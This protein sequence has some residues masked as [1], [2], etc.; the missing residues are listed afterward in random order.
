[1]K[2][3]DQG[4]V[5]VA[6]E[7][8]L[9]RR[10]RIIRDTFPEAY[11]D[12]VLDV[13]TLAALI[14]ASETPEQE[15]YA[16]NW[17]GKSDSLRSQQRPSVASLQPDLERSLG[18]FDA[19]ENVYIEGD[20]LEVLRL[21]QRGY[22]DRIRL[23]YLDPPYNTTNDFVYNDDFT[24]S[25]QTYLEYSGQVNSKGN[26]VSATI[27]T[28]GR[29]HSGWLSFMYPRLALSRN[30]LREDGAIFISIDDNEVHNLR[31]LMDSVFGPENFIGQFIWA[32][33]RKND[34]KFVSESHEYIVVYAR[35]KAQ[36][37]ASVGEWK[38]R[39][40]GLD[41]IYAQ[42]R[43]LK[44]KH[45]KDFSA[46]TEDLKAWY[47]SLAN[48]NPAKRNK[49][50]NTVDENGV[51]FPADISWPGGGGPTYR[52]LHP[53]TGKPCTVPAR[54]WMFAEPERMAEVVAEGRVHFGADETSVP[55]IKA[56]LVDHE[57]EVPYSV[58]YQDGRGATKRLRA[59]MGGDYFEN[60]KDETVLQRIVE[61]ASGPDDIIL[62]L[63]AGSASS[64]HAVLLQNLADGG[65]R[66]FIM[67]NL[68]E[69][70]KEGS[71]AREAG[72]ET[73][74]EIGRTRVAL[75]A[76]ALGLD[77]FQMRF[78]E[79]T[80]SNFKLW[81]SDDAPTDS[82]GLAAMLLEYANTL[83]KD[84]VN[85]GIATEALVK[86]G[87]TLDLPWVRC[88]VANQHVVIVGDTAVC[89][90]KASSPELVKGLLELP[91]KKLIVLDAAFVGGDKDKSNL[92]IGAER[93]KIQMR[94]L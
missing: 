32:A 54:G 72:F 31:V 58:F 63:F 6:T 86:D 91:I 7:S 42:Y 23:I 1:M 75:A 68:P 41:D 67:V 83:R 20:N 92:A 69:L 82:E 49:H 81:N 9:E 38:T 80:S 62:D 25:L 53:R 51:Y 36:L 50:Y 66:R 88:K 2:K 13:A 34:S 70:T 11:A 93:A 37:K 71:A 45:K 26:M 52:V 65:N 8:E 4:R 33:G 5:S 78:F 59:L 12:G 3:D 19:A 90:A 18:D 39:K 15:A 89:L 55:C 57:T 29:R 10:Q 21:L 27:E 84:A 47:R 61:F 60:P 87:V 76:E 24:D 22:N 85:D 30:L 94:V 64:A 48:D 56:Y 40:L 35:N 16:I 46:M 17:A 73:V 77:N 28:G 44:R 74:S 14:G 79:L 43:K